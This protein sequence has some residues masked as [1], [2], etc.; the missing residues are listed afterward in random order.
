MRLVAP[1]LPENFLRQRIGGGPIPT[2]ARH[3]S[4]TPRIPLERVCAQAHGRDRR[5]IR[6]RSDPRHLPPLRPWAGLSAPAP[7]QRPEALSTRPHCRGPVPLDRTA[8]ITPF[9]RDANICLRYCAWTLGAFHTAPPRVGP[10]LSQ[11]S[12]ERRSTKVARSGFD[13]KALLACWTGTTIG[14][15]AW[16]T[17]PRPG[18]VWRSEAVIW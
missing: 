16:G 8:V 13:A 18:G 7:Y 12:P 5:A 3:G 15:V 9:R 11:T 6:K 14:P 2:T 1:Q 10:L 4:R 17:H